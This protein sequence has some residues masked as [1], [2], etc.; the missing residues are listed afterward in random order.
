MHTKESGAHTKNREDCRS[1]SNFTFSSFVYVKY[2]QKACLRRV[3]A[4]LPNDVF[5]RHL[6]L[7]VI[8]VLALCVEGRDI[9]NNYH[10]KGSQCM[11]IE[12]NPLF[13]HAAV[14]WTKFSPS[15]KRRI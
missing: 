9:L 6:C 7:R 1:E 10:G 4:C 8:S 5:A 12:Q 14:R 13:D 2:L 15:L 3:S 11:S